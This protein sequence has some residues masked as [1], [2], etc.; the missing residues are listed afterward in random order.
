[1]AK[2]A[3]TVDLVSALTRC[4]LRI[5]WSLSSDIYIFQIKRAIDADSSIKL[6]FLC[7]PGNPTGT[8]IPLTTI[9][10]LLDYE[11]FKGIVVVDE[12]YIEF[13]N[14]VSKNSAVSLVKDYANLCVMQTFSKSFGLAAI[15]CFFFYIKKTCPLISNQ[16]I[17]SLQAR[18]R[19]RPTPTY[20]NPHQ[21]KS[22]LQH[23]N[24]HRTNRIIRSLLSRP[25]R[26]EIQI[27]CPQYI[28]HRTSFHLFLPRSP[29][30]GPFD[31]RERCQFCFDTYFR[32]R[33]RQ[34]WQRACAQSV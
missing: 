22:T 1:M 27:I 4:E 32:E 26:H 17:S 24:T 20:P 8:L 21:H 16:S 29:R 6:I 28:T 7:S 13:S 10:S 12:A 18:N 3:R 33:N 9:R 34:T 23:L 2:E 31:R 30:V 5:S 11:K 19:H 14:D 15:R 25:C